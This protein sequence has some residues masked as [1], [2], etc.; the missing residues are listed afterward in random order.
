MPRGASSLVEK[1]RRALIIVLQL[2]CALCVERKVMWFPDGLDTGCKSTERRVWQRWGEPFRRCWVVS[3]TKAPGLESKG[4]GTK[5]D[6][7]FIRCAH[8]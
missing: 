5:Y 8:V 1:T 6:P 3:Y 7:C 4:L 2:D